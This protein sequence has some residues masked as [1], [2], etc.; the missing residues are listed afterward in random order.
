LD[1]GKD[2]LRYVEE[3]HKLPTVREEIKEDGT[4]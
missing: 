4:I 1:D 2:T 3:D